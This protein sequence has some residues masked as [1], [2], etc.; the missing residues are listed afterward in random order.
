MQVFSFVSRSDLKFKNKMSR[1]LV[2]PPQIK[3]STPRG[4]ESVTT[5]PIGHS[6]IPTDV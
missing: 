2:I 6:P 1:R 3:L 5:T 4:R